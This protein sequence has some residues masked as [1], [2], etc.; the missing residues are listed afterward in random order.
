MLLNILFPKLDTEI[1]EHQA[2]DRPHVFECKYSQDGH[3]ILGV[4]LKYMKFDSKRM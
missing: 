3:E 1:T 4:F 2:Q